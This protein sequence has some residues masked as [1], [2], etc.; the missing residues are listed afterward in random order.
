MFEDYSE[1]ELLQ[2]LK[3]NCGHMQVKATV[4]FQEKG[5]KKLEDQ[6]R[7]E[8]NFGNAGAVENLL[9]AAVQKEMARG[10]SKNLAAD[11]FMRLEAEDVDLGPDNDDSSDP[12]LPLDKLYRMETVTDK[13]RKL[14]PARQ[15]AED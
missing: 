5:L 3:L 12:F 6:R 15:L 11:E 4:S 2:I 8:P 7:S 14:Y 1:S 9:K 10:A 13:L